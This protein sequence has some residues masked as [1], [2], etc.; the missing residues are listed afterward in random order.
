MNHETIYFCYFTYLIY[1][2]LL[3]RFKKLTLIA[4]GKVTSKN[5]Y[6]LAITSYTASYIEG[7]NSIKVLFAQFT[8][9]IYGEHIGEKHFINADLRNI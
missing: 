4:I 5:L 6:Y 9:L 3:Q 8:K 2:T 1:S 7:K